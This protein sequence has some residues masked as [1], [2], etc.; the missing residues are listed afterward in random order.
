MKN[1]ILIVLVVLAVYGGYALW[2]N[3]H[4]PQP[5][6][7]PTIAESTPAPTPEPTATPPPVAAVTPRP[8]R[9]APPGTFYLVQAL[10]VTTDTGVTDLPP[11]TEVQ[12]IGDAPGLI[13]VQCRDG[14][15]F[16]AY[17]AQITND[18]DVANAAVLTYSAAIRNLTRA[19]VP[20]AQA[21]QPPPQPQAPVRGRPL[22]NSTV[23]PQ[24]AA[25]IAQIQDQIATHRAA[26]Q[27]LELQI[28][29]AP[30]HDR[31]IVGRR[32]QPEMDQH[33]DQIDALQKQLQ[34]LG[35]AAAPL[36]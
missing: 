7:Q 3:N 33:Q 8:K 25:Q 30:P 16:S 11:G 13:V 32:L 4:V 23:D 15:K 24:R 5:A 2:T 20:Q 34:A 6:P 22:A 18:L 26:I 14:T 1:A 19:P 31:V 27:N 21:Y 35:N 29:E 36:Q 28:G 10:S 9:L 17:P 12:H